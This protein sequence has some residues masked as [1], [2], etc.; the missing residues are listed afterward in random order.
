MKNKLDNETKIGS[1]V[2]KL[3]IRGL[4]GLLAL[5]TVSSQSGCI[6][7]LTE[8]KF[9]ESSRTLRALKNAKLQ[10]RDLIYGG[11]N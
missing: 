3:A 4:V 8:N 10:K 2:G 6:T 7:E 9:K 1:K 11:T 5:A